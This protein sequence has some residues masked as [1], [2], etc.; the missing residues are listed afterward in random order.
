MK[1][2]QLSKFCIGCVLSRVSGKIPKSYRCL[3]LFLVCLVHRWD[4]VSLTFTPYPFFFVSPVYDQNTAKLKKKI[5]KVCSG[6][7]PFTIKKFLS[8]FYEIICTFDEGIQV[9]KKSQ[10]KKTKVQFMVKI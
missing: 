4:V 1:K 9:S 2:K 5:F 8:T 10:C 7:L 6:C 3:F